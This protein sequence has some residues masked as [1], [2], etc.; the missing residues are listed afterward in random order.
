[1]RN[2]DAGTRLRTELAAAEVQ[3]EQIQALYAA[4]ADDKLQHPE[5]R[6][7]I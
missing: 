3:L 4:L 7:L 1:M 5:F 6:V 2:E